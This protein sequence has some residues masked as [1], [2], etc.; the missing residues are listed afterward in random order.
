M[1]TKKCIRIIAFLL[2]TA[3]LFSGCGKTVNNGTAT[4]K[5]SE[6]TTEK[7]EDNPAGPTGQP[8]EQPTEVPA[9]YVPVIRFAVCSDVHMSSK[10]STEAKRFEKLFDSAYKYAESQEYKNLDAVI[11]VGDMTNQGL[12]TELNAFRGIIDKKC[13]EGTQ[14]ITVMGNH[15][16]M[17]A[18]PEVYKAN[19]DP[20]LNKHVV[21]NGFHFIG[22]SPGEAGQ[23]YDKDTINWLKNELAAANEQDPSKPIFTFRHHH[24]QNTVYV[25]KSWYTASSSALKSA[26]GKYP[27]IIDFSGDSHGPVNNPLSIMQDKFTTLGTGT[28][29]YFEMEK[30]MTD[31]TLPKGKEKAAQYYIVEVDANNVV[32]IQPYNILTDDFFRTPS[33]TDDASEQLV[34][35]IEKPSDASSFAYTSKRKDTAAAPY[36]S[37]DAE[38]TVSGV[39]YTKAKITVPQAFDDSCIYSYTLTLSTGG[40]VEKTYKYFSEY[41]FE[42]I[43]D[44]V[45]YTVSSL[46]SGTEYEVSV[47]P[48]NA[49]GIE[50]EPIKTTFRTEN[51]EKIKYSPDHD[52]TYMWTV[53][54]FENVSEL[55]KSSGTPAY[56]GKIS[57][58]VFAGQWD[59]NA[60]NSDCVVKIAEG[61]GFNGSKAM[62]VT[63]T[64]VP[65]NRSWYLF[66]TSTNKFTDEFDD[67]K[68]LRVWVDFTGIDFRKACFGLVDSAGKLYS[69]D[70]LDNNSDLQFYYLAE[71]SSAWKTYRHGNDGCFGA[72]QDSSVKNFKGWLAFPTND[73]AI[74]GGGGNR[75]GGNNITGIYM[76]FDFSDSSMCG[77]EFYIDEISLVAD[78]KTFETYKK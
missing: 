19:C 77:K 55:T 50:G 11:V 40:K 78:Y 47:T 68:Y 37:S 9:P 58:D 38:I 25:S 51:K 61:K 29:S 18:G 59:G 34:Y 12:K 21:I 62:S 65:E 52:V 39:S 7:P 41:Y 53:T 14:V 30:G 45:S 74:R 6:Q 24:L 31:G 5:P 32:K 63:K 60:S 73:F 57:G 28:L 64:G 4:E 33:N 16:Y 26:M 8:S 3:V 48:V 71:G 22:I 72:A 17:N 44:T 49:W 42:P 70:D 36:F 56:D 66:T 46:K 27:Q 15:E 13:K 67:T 2:L 69:T 20:E 75:F 1:I 43:P 10:T 35:Y 23:T 54:D 76:Y